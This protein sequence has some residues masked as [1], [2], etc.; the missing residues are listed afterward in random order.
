MVDGEV[1]LMVIYYVSIWA[2]IV[3]GMFDAWI[4]RQMMVEYFLGLLSRR[5]VWNRFIFREITSEYYGMFLNFSGFY[6]FNDYI[7]SWFISITS[8]DENKNTVRCNHSRGVCWLISTNCSKRI[9]YST[10]ENV[11]LT[12]KTYLQNMIKARG[13][14]LSNDRLFV[15]F[16]VPLKNFSWIMKRI[17]QDVFQWFMIFHIRFTL[18]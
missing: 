13:C 3:G 16:D 17:I 10:I 6:L 14:T 12:K 4:W 1:I 2:V 11:Q 5:S 8:V 15:S 18:E 9:K 7:S